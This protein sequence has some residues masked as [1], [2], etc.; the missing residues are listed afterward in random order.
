MLSTMREIS[1]PDLRLVI[2]RFD[3]ELDSMFIPQ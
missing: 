3:G 2:N 1:T